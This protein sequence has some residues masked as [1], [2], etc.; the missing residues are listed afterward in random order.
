MD[1]QLNLILTWFQQLDIKVNV[2]KLKRQLSV[3]N[4]WVKYKRVGVFEAVTGFGKT[5]VAIIGIY[6][7]NLAYPLA[8]IIVVVPSAKLFK[9]WEDHII[10]FDLKNVTVYVVNT[11]TQNFIETRQRYKC[12]FLICDEVHRVLG[13]RGIQ[14][15][16][17]IQCTEFDMFL[18]LTAT[19]ELQERQVLADLNIPIVDTITM[20]EARRFGYV[21]DYAIYNL[22]NTINEQ[23]REKYNKV[24]D[25]YHGTFAKF[26]Y[27]ME[28]TQNIQLIKACMVSDIKNALVGNEWNT[29]LGWRTWYAT[30]M[31]WD[32]HD[33]TH[34]WSPDNLRKYA[35]Q[36]NYALGARKTFLYEVYEK[37]NVTRQ[38]IEKFKV[39]TITFAET[40]N[41]VDKLVHELTLYGIKSRAYHSNIKPMIIHQKEKAYRNRKNALLFKK[42]VN[43]TIIDEGDGNYAIEY[44]KEIKIAGKNLKQKIINE[45]EDKVIDVLCTAK[46]LDEGLN[47]EGIELVIICSATGKKRARIQRTGRGLRFAIG[48]MARIVNLYILD[49]QD[50]VWL[51]KSQKGETN[52]RY[53][54]DINEIL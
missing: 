53:I 42:R 14:F 43:G 12:T 38:L 26:N 16:K 40:T 6:R 10:N 11:Y 28:F 37:I 25:I 27:Y 13:T 24:N 4:N 33:K 34:P 48:K 44:D 2:D 17:T 51:K 1:E 3:I 19:L 50:E 29:A 23:E 41:F 31:G 7:L 30:E 35:N 32:G 46:A 47:I 22:G 45:F 39:P 5:Y 36:W 18:G 15:N 52:I 54:T 21:S 8:T 49:S 20:S 9:D